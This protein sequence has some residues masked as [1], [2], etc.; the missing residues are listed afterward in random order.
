MST[1]QIKRSQSKKYIDFPQALPH[2]SLD[3]IWSESHF[4]EL[5]SPLAVFNSN[6]HLQ[7]A[8]VSMSKSKDWESKSEEEKVPCN[9]NDADKKSNDSSMYRRILDKQD[10]GFLSNNQI[11]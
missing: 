8:L 1:Q 4:S 5:Y 2:K 11:H 9:L 6:L 10:W 3:N 7:Q